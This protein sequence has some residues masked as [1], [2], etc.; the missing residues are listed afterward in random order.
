[1][2][3]LKLGDLQARVTGG[4]DGE[5]SGAGP[6]V[7]L[8]HGFGAPGDDLVS[9]HRVID[10]PKE[11]RFVFPHA[12]IALPPMYGEGRAWWMVDFGKIEEAARSGDPRIL[13]HNE[14]EGLDAARSLLDG[15]L[16]AIEKELSPSHLVVGGFSQGAM[17]SCDALLRSERNV[18]GLV[19]LSGT[20]VAAN[21]WLPRLEARK[22]QRAFLSHGTNDP[23]LPH[24]VSEA[25]VQIFRE[26]GW[27]TTW[28][29]FRGG[30]EIP[31]PVLA[32]LGS[33]LHACTG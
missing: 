15:L 31:M 20:M 21:A 14:P 19:M 27:D 9:L 32:E 11:T 24:F 1:M 5:G 13:T 23:I 29:P 12:P 18:S 22:G 4:V 2:R 10:A 17:L 7:V 16:D 6:I 33:F 25:L 28:V 3:T 8:L 30:H 26:N